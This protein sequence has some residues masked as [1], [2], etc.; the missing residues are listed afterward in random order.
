MESLIGQEIPLSDRTRLG[1]ISRLHSYVTKCACV[2]FCVRSCTFMSVR[3]CARLHAGARVCLRVCLRVRICISVCKDVGL[4]L[5]LDVCPCMN[6]RVGGK[7]KRAD[8]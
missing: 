3:V 8:E 4:A 1:K 2:C 5:M 7:P 6:E